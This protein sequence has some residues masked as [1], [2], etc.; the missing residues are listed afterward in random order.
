[1]NVARLGIDYGTTNTVVVCSDRGR[2]PVVPHITETAVGP[3]AREVFPSLVVLDRETG[4][5]IFGSEA[6]R[7]LTRPGAEKRYGVLG[8][9]KRLLRDYADGRRVG[10]SIV[11]E[12]LDLAAVLREFCGALRASIMRSGF[13]AEN[14][15]LETVITWPANANGAQRYVTRKSFKDA[16]VEILATLTEPAASAIEFADRL[17]RGNRARARQLEASIAVFDLGGGTFDVSLVRIHGPEFTVVDTA[18]IEQLGGDDFDRILAQRLAEA[19]KI[20]FDGLRPFQRAMLLLHARQQ[21]ESIS[22]GPAASLTFAAD[23][24]GLGSGVGTVPVK[25]YFKEL[26]KLLEPAIEKLWSL[27]NGAAA[28]SAGIQSQDLTAIYLVGGS[29][30]LPLVPKMLAR[31]FRDVRLVMTDKPFTS[32][33]MGAAIRSAEGVRLQE[34]LSRTFGVLRLAEHGTRDCFDPIFAAGTRLPQRHESPLRH[35]VRYS[36]RHNIGHL[37]YLECAGVNAAGWPSDGVRQWSDIL[38]PYDPAIPVGSRLT[39]D[40]IVPR[41]DLADQ[42]VE[43]KY[44]CD[45]DGVITVTIRRLSDGQ[46]CTYEI[47]RN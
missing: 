10:Q 11:P 23:D 15:P 14:E 6:E 40:Q 21:K 35:K 33:A 28:R 3:V 31:R 7:C 16:G 47:F 32:T 27:I 37:R 19:V 45:A 46:S 42:W 13:F 26:E 43:E 25:A 39:P 8:S 30:K 29:S 44:I 4:Q 20:D 5:L 12:G 17:A 22:A 2:Y 1:M 36:P 24:L 34:I 38:F 41:D 18:G 9:L